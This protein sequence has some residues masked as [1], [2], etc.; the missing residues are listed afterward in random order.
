M[1]EKIVIATTNLQEDDVVDSF[2][3]KL[4]IDCFRGSSENVLDRF[5]K[6]AKKYKANL[7][8]RLT[9]DNPLINPKIIDDFKNI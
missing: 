2:A 1:V 8:I 7:I 4:G 9:A 3:K 6:C 5:Y